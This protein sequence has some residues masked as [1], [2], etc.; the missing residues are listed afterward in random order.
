MS[1]KEDIETLR[2]ELAEW[3]E[4]VRLLLPVVITLPC[5]TPNAAEA[6]KA[7]ASSMRDAEQLKPRSDTFWELGIGMLKMLSSKA[8]LGH[9]A[10]VVDRAIDV[11][12][13]QLIPGQE[14]E[15]QAG[16]AAARKVLQCKLEA[17]QLLPVG[18][19]ALRGVALA[20]AHVVGHLARLL[21]ALVL[22]G[23]P[24]Q[25]LRALAHRLRHGGLQSQQLRGQVGRGGSH[26]APR[27]NTRR[28]RSALGCGCSH[29]TT[30]CG[31]PGRASNFEHG[32]NRRPVLT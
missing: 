14:G 17:R 25:P 31:R 26:P 15:P 4:A 32:R 6:T 9:H 22:L 12:A 1:A 27:P 8:A 20:P 23:P 21:V 2:T 28:Q 24:Q 10:V 5:V 29:R 16:I 3:E 11:D 30:T 19:A 13:D 7:L 18:A